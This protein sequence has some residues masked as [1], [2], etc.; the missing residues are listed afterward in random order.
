MSS[1]EMEPRAVGRMWLLDL[2]QPA[3]AVAPR[4][5]AALRRV[6]GA[7]EAELERAMGGAG[8]SVARLQT[9]RRAYAAWVEGELAAY[10]WVSFEDEAIGEH[11]LRLRLRPGEAYLWDFVTRPANRGQGL[12]SAL[13]A[14]ILHELSAEGVRRA[15][16]GADLDNT[17][18]HHGIER[19]GFRAVA[20]LVVAGGPAEPAR[21]VEGLPGVPETL[22]AAA[23]YA[24]LGEAGSLV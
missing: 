14:F 9:G 2:D 24:L 21:S 11:G 5:A 20:D 10:G 23:R 4:V 7:D 8:A 22:V 6:T 16:I 19:A 3:P 17:A 15:W 12:Y 13:L 1:D 18:S